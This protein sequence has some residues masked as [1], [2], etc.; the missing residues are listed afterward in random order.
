MSCDVFNLKKFFEGALIN[1][2]VFKEQN[3][4]EIYV[5]KLNITYAWIILE[6]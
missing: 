3:D 4:W 6:N 1:W 2:S 5:L